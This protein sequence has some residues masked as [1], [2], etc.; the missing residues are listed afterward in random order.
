[1]EIY[2]ILN[3]PKKNKV[4]KKTSKLE[5]SIQFNEDKEVSIW[6]VE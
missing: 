2:Q 6:I 1:M 4:E 3:D 5:K